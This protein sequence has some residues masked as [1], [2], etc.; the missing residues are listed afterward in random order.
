MMPTYD[1]LSIADIIALSVLTLPFWACI[2][3][4]IYSELKTKN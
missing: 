2:A 4:I 1:Q 3:S